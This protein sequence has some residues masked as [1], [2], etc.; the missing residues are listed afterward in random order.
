M[1]K[2][3]HYFTEIA[4]SPVSFFCIHAQEYN[5]MTKSEIKSAVHPDL[6]FVV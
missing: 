5:I 2:A 4:Q 3:P 6:L 1:R